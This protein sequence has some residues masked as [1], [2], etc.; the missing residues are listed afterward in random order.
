MKLRTKVFGIVALLAPASCV[1]TG[2]LYLRSEGFQ[3]RLREYLQARIEQATGMQCSIGKLELEAWRGRFKVS[4]LTLEPRSGEAGFLWLNAETLEGRLRIRSIWHFTADL[5]YLDIVRPQ[6]RIV[7]GAERRGPGGLGVQS[8]LHRSLSFATHRISLREGEL[9]LNQTQI[10]LDLSLEDFDCELS[11]QEAPAG[12]SAA[13]S[14][15][16]GT[17]VYAGRQIEHGLT[18]KFRLMESGLQIDDF[19]VRREQSEVKGHGFLGPWDAPALTLTVG[20]AVFGPDFKLLDSDFAG[21]Q[22]RINVTAD[23][24]WDSTGIS[25]KGRF[26]LPAADYHHAH[27]HGAEGLFQIHDRALELILAHVRM[28][29]D[30]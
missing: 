29:R 8:V 18:A 9:L 21:A 20:G 24:R 22:G 7:S 5:E 28:K 1:L 11:H 12:Y 27:L 15:R 10:L 30:L 14:Y 17:V 26:S 19:E 6:V 2:I 25:M 16:R 4:A 23:L 3:A 13:L